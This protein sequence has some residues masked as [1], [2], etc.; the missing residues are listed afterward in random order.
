MHSET[1]AWPLGAEEA[2]SRMI[3]STAVFTA[4]TVI[5]NLSPLKIPAPYAPFLIYEFWEV[6]IVAVFLLYGFKPGVLVALVNTGILLAVF[7]GALPTGPLYNLAAVLAMLTG[8]YLTYKLT[9]GKLNL[10]TPAK[11]VSLTAFSAASLRTIV[12]TAVNLVCLP[13]P[14]PVGFALPFETLAAVLPLT[15]VFNA[16]ITL[17]TVPLGYLAAKTVTSVRMP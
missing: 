17:Y 9:R 2:R 14:P 11:T 4:L 5:L 3:A 8:I 13:Q 16:T 7:P 1:Q 10:K 12:M 6:P 15:A